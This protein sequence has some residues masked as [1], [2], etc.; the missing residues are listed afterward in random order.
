[1]AMPR[2][3]AKRVQGNP[4]SNQAGLREG[5][6]SGLEKRNADHLAKH[7]QPVIFEQHK[8]RY[9]VPET[10]RTYTPDFLLKSN[11]VIVE[12]KGRFLPP[13]RAKHMLVKAQHPELDI[14]FVF[15]NPNAPLY[16]GS[17]TTLA[18][19]AEKYDFKWAAK[20]IPPSWWQEPGPITVVSDAS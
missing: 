7:G 15:S 11:G 19:W 20:L 8:I 17:S 4:K 3:W 12:T 14:R 10:R 5:F 13:D 6:R 18:D 9:V 16:K 2:H 1:M